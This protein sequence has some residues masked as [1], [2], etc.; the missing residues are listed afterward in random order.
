MLYWLRIALLIEKTSES[1]QMKLVKVFS[2]DEGRGR[3][4]CSEVAV[5]PDKKM[6][7]VERF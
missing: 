5:T 1:V 6:A 3:T 2:D 4:N 7:T